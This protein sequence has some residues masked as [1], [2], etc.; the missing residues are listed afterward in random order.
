MSDVKKIISGIAYFFFSFVFFQF[1]LKEFDM[2]KLEKIKIFGFVHILTF[3]GDVVW[4]FK[5]LSIT[6]VL[7]ILT[8][9]FTLLNEQSFHLRGNVSLRDIGFFRNTKTKPIVLVFFLSVITIASIF[10]NSKIPVEELSF[11]NMLFIFYISVVISFNDTLIM[12]P[13]KYLRS[14]TNKKILVYVA[15]DIFFVTTQVISW[16]ICN[17]R[18]N[19][20]GIISTVLWGFIYMYTYDASDYSIYPL[21]ILISVR[22]VS[23]FLS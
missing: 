8:L 20:L 15:Y 12:R 13:F 9:V 10:Y 2:L 1:I 4:Q 16:A 3:K 22:F 5:V 7:A 23:V 18:I 6:T 11:F 17:V 21:W 14:I 19:S